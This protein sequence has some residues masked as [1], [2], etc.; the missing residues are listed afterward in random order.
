MSLGTTTTTP[1][2]AKPHACE[3]CCKPI[4]R[5]ERYTRVKG[6]WE[7]EWQN[8]GAHTICLELHGYADEG[9]CQMT[10]G[11]LMEKTR[12]AEQLEAF[13]A[14]FPPPDDEAAADALEEF[15]VIARR[16]AAQAAAPTT[17]RA[18]WSWPT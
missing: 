9:L 6:R 16:Q 4:D 18:A 3:I 1:V 10:W 8:W 12:S 13:L 2:A 11:E 17:A 14:R 5:G 7:G 15:Q